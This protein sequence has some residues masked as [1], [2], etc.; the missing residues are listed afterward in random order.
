MLNNGLSLKQNDLWVVPALLMVVGAAM[1]AQFSKSFFVFGSAAILLGLFGFI[2]TLIPTLDYLN[3]ISKSKKIVFLF[4]LFLA[5]GILLRFALN[6]EYPPPNSYLSIDEVKSGAWA[7]DILKGNCESLFVPVFTMAYPTSLAFAVLGT[8]YNN[9]RIAFVIAGILT[10]PFFFLL[11][12]EILDSVTALLALALLSLSAY[13]N[14]VGRLAIDWVHVPL[15]TSICFYFFWLGWK[16]DQKYFVLNGLFVGVSLLSYYALRMV[17]ILEILVYPFVYFCSHERVPNRKAK[18]VCFIS[19]V[20][21]MSIPAFSSVKLNPAIWLGNHDAGKYR[22]LFGMDLYLLLNLLTTRCGLIFETFLRNIGIVGFVFCLVGICEFVVKMFRGDAVSIFVLFWFFLNALGGGF[23]E[24]FASHRLIGAFLPALIFCAVGVK[25]SAFQM[26]RV[27]FVFKDSSAESL[28]KGVAIFLYALFLVSYGLENLQLHQKLLKGTEGFHTEA[29]RTCQ[30][31]AKEE[32]FVYEV[33]AS[34]C[35]SYNFNWL[36][37]NGR[38]THIAKL[39]GLGSKHG[40]DEDVL[41]IYQGNELAD[42]YKRIESLYG[43]KYERISQARFK[44]YDYSVIR[45]DKDRLGL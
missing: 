14:F 29:L 35:T 12:R 40:S 28:R 15:L 26:S 34:N 43:V 37:P 10:L 39:S 21:L 8:D 24:D 17:P 13:H 38:W 20:L 44:N 11:V 30:K 3:A 27:T 42:F 1:L 9:L 32:A 7:N 5:G 36:L 33:G 41:Y 6:A 4:L 19:F 45:I 2:L 22:Y 18:A 25:S 16:K 31:L 23:T